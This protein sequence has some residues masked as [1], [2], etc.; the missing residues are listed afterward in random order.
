MSGRAP[1]PLSPAAPRLNT[2]AAWHIRHGVDTEQALTLLTSGITSR[3]IAHLLGRDAARL[4]HRSAGLRQWTAR[5]HIDGWTQQYRASDY[6]VQDLLDYVRIPSDPINQLLDNRAATTALT[7]LVAGTPDG[8]VNVA[9]PSA[10]P[11]D[12][13]R[14]P[15][16]PPSATSTSSRCSTAAWTSTTASTTA[17]SSPPGAPCSAGPSAGLRLNADIRMGVEGGGTSGADA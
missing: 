10:A 5:H 8:P 7:R 13:P 17:T 4:G 16:R 6:E 15:A 9:R 1:P 3:R 12:H 14:H 11:P 2:H